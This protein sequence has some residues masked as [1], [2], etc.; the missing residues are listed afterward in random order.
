M[1]RYSVGEELFV[2]HFTISNSR[3]SEL[4]SAPLRFWNEDVSNITI[5]KLTVTEHHRVLHD[6]AKED[7]APTCDGF[8]LKDEDGAIWTNQ[9]PRA[10]YGQISD[11][12]DRLFWKDGYKFVGSE[13]LNDVIIPADMRL[14]TDYMWSLHEG[15]VKLP[16][17]S[18]TPARQ[19][20][21]ARVVKQ[22][23]DEFNKELVSKALWDKH[24]DIRHYVLKD[25]V[26]TEI[27]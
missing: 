12:A 18:L 10:S 7:E 1:A 15:I 23:K 8:I 13:R 17:D 16:D 14:L 27:V 25:I 21:F 26:K 3:V 2:I 6:Y 24:P 11:A 20:L 19:D 22:L 5:K 9:Y 4:F